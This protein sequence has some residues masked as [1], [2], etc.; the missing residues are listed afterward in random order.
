LGGCFLIEEQRWLRLGDQRSTRTAEI[1]AER[2]GV[3]A[4]VVSL[5][6]AVVGITLVLRLV[7]R[8]PLA[9][10]EEEDEDTTVEEIE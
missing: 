10:S 8:A 6:I 4:F 5:A 2:E 7:A 9:D 3:L 1:A